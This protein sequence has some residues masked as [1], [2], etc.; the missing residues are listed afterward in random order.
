MPRSG[1]VAHSLRSFAARSSS[2]DGRSPNPLTRSLAGAPCPAPIAWLT[3]YAR[4]LLALPRGTV[5]PRTPLHA[6]SRGPR[7]PLRSRGSL[8]TLVRCSLFLVGRS[9]PEPPYTLSRGGPVPRSG[10]VAHSLRSFAARSSS[11]DGR[12]PN[13][14]TRSLAGAPCP[15]PVAWLTRYA[16]SLLAL[17]RGTVVPRTPLH[18]LSRGPRAPLRSRGSLAT[19]V[20]C[21]LFLVGRSFPE[22][23]YTLSR[24]GPVPRSDRVAHSLRSFAARSSSWDGRS[25]NPLTRFL[26]PSTTLGAPRACRGAGASIPAPACA[27]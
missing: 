25:P 2:W 23:P 13:P 22:P 12:S 16:R 5:V 19:L 1:R 21:S 8:A 3:R 6:L 26:A 11:W 4:S 10:R 17:P 24:G 7:A 14:L 15:A 9:F 27:P 20:R 18:A